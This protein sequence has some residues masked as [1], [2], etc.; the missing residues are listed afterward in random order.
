[1]KVEPGVMVPLG[2]GKYFRSDRIV[3]LEP[4]EEGRGPGKLTQ[5]YI[6]NLLAP[7]IASRNEGAIL[8]DMVAM[9]T[10]V[11]KAQE[12]REL[13]R[14]ILETISEFNPVLRSIIRDQGQW[15]LDRLEEQLKEV[16]RDEDEE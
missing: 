10:E 7:A 13:L 11:T 9:S 4:I 5:V 16:L 6:E 14:D 2:Y 8:R 3:R 15:N 1:M 12:Q